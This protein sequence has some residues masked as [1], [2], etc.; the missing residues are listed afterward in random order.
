MNSEYQYNEIKRRVKQFAI[1]NKQEIKFEISTSS[2]QMR[3]NKKETAENRLF[4][5]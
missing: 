2:L 3:K 1:K 5:N 4:V